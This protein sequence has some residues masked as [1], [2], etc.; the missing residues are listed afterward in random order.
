MNFI[1]SLFLFLFSTNIFSKTEQ[2]SN[3]KDDK[4][5][6]IVKTAE[7]FRSIPRSKSK[8]TIKTIKAGKTTSYDI[9]ILSSTDKKAYLEFTA[10]PEEHGRR[11]LAIGKKYWSKF[12]DSR[13]VVPIH[14]R[15]LIGNSAFVVA[16][17]FAIDVDQDYTPKIIKHVIINKIKCILVRLIKKHN[18]APYYRIDY[19]T[20]EK[21]YYPVKANFYSMSGKHI[22]TMIIEKSKK[23]AGKLRPSVMKMKDEVTKDRISWWYT[24]KIIITTIPEN[25]FTKAYLRGR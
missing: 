25:V 21:N 23:L 10:P 17:L 11:M 22:K 15:E 16:D 12:P 24:K 13:R 19:Y 9:N 18:G 4:A 20:T 8:I 1:L 5:Y 3:P 14:R 2:I 7:N 6:K